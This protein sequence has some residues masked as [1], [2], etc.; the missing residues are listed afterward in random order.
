MRFCGQT[1]YFNQEAIQ[2]LRMWLD[3]FLNFGAHISEKLKKAKIAE[4]R[5]KKLSKTYGLS[6]ALLRKIQIIAVQSVTLYGVE[7]WWKNQ[8]SHQNKLQKLINQQARSIIKMYPST[9]IAAFIGESGLMPAHIL[10]DFRQRKY[11]CRIFSLPNSI[12]TKEILPITLLVGDRNA[13]P[14]HLSKDDLTWASNQ[15]ITIYG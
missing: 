7:L 13:Q 9:F 1:V 15:R 8:K 5:I 4:I 14:K 2:W 6:P 3:S 12:P 11:A 10:L